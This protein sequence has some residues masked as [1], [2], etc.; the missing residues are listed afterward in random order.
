MA[1]ITIL[2]EEVVSEPRPH[3]PALSG[4]PNTSEVST[5]GAMPLASRPSRVGLL[6]GSLVV[7]LFIT[8]VVS[9][10]LIW[11]RMQSRRHRAGIH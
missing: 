7:I 6:F 11:S 9:G 1:K 3:P 4:L 8:A 10:W 5:P 2:P